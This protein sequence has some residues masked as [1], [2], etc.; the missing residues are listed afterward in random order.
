MNT[1][2][3][4]ALAFFLAHKR[5]PSPEELGAESHPLAATKHLVFVT[6]YKDGRIVASSGRVEPKKPN[7]IA[8][9]ADNATLCAQDKRFA[10][11]GITKPGDVENLRCRVDVIDKTHRRM[12]KNASEVDTLREGM[13]IISQS[14]GKLGI[15]LP[16]I[17]PAITSSQELYEV[18]LR[19]AELPAST[20]QESLVIYALA[21]QVF[22]DF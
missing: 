13:L 21:S 11:A 9:C 3:K 8:E 14:E 15:V 10:A 6:F 5:S 16:G 2:A 7:T 20:P 4:K 22:S 1:L 18:A 17:A 12:V 19:K